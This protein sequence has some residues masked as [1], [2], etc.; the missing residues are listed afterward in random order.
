M[1]VKL[2]LLKSGENIISDSKGGFLDEKLV[3]YVLEKPC[4]VKVNGTY[5]VLDDDEEGSKDKLSISLHPWPL[6]SKDT[7]VE[8]VYDW[9]ISI[10]NPTEELKKMYET[11]VLGIN[12]DES[13]ESIVSTEQSDSDQSD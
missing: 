5:K 2:I 6:L 10:V 7:T 8:V 3:C 12:E 11:Q 9:V 4:L 1:A 13:N